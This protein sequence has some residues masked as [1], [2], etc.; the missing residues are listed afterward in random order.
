MVLSSLL[1]ASIVAFYGIIAF[2][3]LV[4]PHIVRK[5]IGGD[6]RFLL[7]AAA[8]SGAV[9]LLLCDIVARSLLS[10]VVIPVGILTS[11]IG[12]PLFILL[13]IRRKQYW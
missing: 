5:L 2:V 3:G 13:L 8:V 7:P 9:F 11:L 1:T 4:V 12:A 6:E 10:P